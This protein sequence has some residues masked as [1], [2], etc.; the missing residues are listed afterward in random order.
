MPGR[1]EAPWT[2]QPDAGLSASACQLANHRP[3][4]GK[5][6]NE[7]GRYDAG[8]FLG[9]TRRKESVF[10]AQAQLSLPALK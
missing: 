3:G 9:L 7:T 4:T 10:K 2:Q 1:P 6:P 5:V 8:R